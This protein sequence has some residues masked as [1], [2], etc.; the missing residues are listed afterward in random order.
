MIITKKTVERML[1][2][3]ISVPNPTIQDVIDFTEKASDY[4]FAGILSSAYF[5]P[6]AAER[7]HKKG[8]KIVSVVDYPMGGSDNKIRL[9][10]AR[11]AFSNGA[12][13][14]DVSMNISAFMAGDYQRVK[15]EIMPFLELANGEKLIKIIYFATLLT[16]D[17]QLKAA[18]LCI[19]CGV[20]Y[21]K[22]N[23]GH[24]SVSKPEEVKLIKDHFGDAIKVMV[25]GGVRTGEDARRMIL[26]GCDRIA[27]SAPFRILDT[28]LE[29]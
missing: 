18:E 3:S 27:T 17:Q 22:T 2:A 9:I 29:E 24:G 20:E 19:D 11:A 26:S 4:D 1:D 25:S 23:T 13:S 10:A 6:Y 15:D 12:D 14:L 5:V 16:P 28:F 21:L 7:A 8:R